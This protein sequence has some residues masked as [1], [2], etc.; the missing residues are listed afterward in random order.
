M[1][2]G[3]SIHKLILIYPSREDVFVKDKKRARVNGE[4]KYVT[5]IEKDYNQEKLTGKTCFRVFIKGNSDT[6]EYLHEEVCDIP[7]KFTLEH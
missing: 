7:Y 3:I 5:S 2:N 1:E 4:D 6:E